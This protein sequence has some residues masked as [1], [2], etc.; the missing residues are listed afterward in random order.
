MNGEGS[1]YSSLDYL[2][3]LRFQDQPKLAGSS[4]VLDEAL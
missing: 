1:I 4:E 2:T 3:L